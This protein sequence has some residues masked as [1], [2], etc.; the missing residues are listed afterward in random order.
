MY[1]EEGRRRKAQRREAFCFSVRRLSCFYVRGEAVKI[2]FIGAG[3]VGTS[4]ALLLQRAGETVVGVASRSPASAEAF[5]RRLGCPVL[6]PPEVARRADVLFLTTND[7]ALAK[8]AG[9]LGTAAAFRAGQVVLHT[10]GAL[11]SAVLAPA[12]ARGAYTVSLHPLQT[13]ASVDEAL[14]LLPGSYFSIEGDDRGYPVALEIVRKLGGRCFFLSAPA[15]VLYHAA[16]C[17]A[18]NYLVGLVS[19]SL[20]MLGAAGVPEEMRLE[21]LLPLLKGTLSNI[22]RLGIPAALT[23]PLAR[24]DVGTVRAHLEALRPFPDLAR[25][26][27]VLG[28]QTL[29]VAVAK[30]NLTP[31]QAEALRQA[32]LAE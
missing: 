25:V 1:L 8:V 13:F 18:S 29:G 15:K 27:R 6:P 5:A 9:E 14:A 20:A 2:G 24:G 3:K 32:L 28:E 7:D 10:S 4:L 19:C 12:A 26:Y 30:G 23:G 11:T 17:V 31:Q 21:A 16:A 22:E